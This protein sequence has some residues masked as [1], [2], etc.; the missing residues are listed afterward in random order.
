MADLTEDSWILLAASAF[1]WAV[2]FQ[3]LIYKKTQATHGPFERVL[4]TPDHT[5][6]MVTLS[7]YPTSFFKFWLGWVF[8]AASGLSCLG[9]RVIFGILNHWTTR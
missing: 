4:K 3:V 2:L 7:F 9:A 6:R 8:A 1:Y 5:L